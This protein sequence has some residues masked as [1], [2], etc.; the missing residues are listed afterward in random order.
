MQHTNPRN[1][2]GFPGVSD[3]FLTSSSVVEALMLLMSVFHVL[4]SLILDDSTIR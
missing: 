2:G 1:S 3:T 4:V